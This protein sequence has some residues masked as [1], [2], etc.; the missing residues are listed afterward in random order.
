MAQSSLPSLP[1]EIF[2]MICDELPTPDLAALV[3]TCCHTYHR[4]IHRFAQRYVEVYLDFSDTSLNHLHAISQNHIMRQYVQRLVVMAPE[5]YLGRD[6][7]WHRTAAGHLRN[8]RDISSIRRFRDDLVHRLVNCRSFIISPIPSPEPEPSETEPSRDDHLVPDDVAYILWDIIADA[9]LPI[10]LFWYGKGMN[11]TSE[12]MDIKRLPKHL[13]GNA[14]FRASW[15]QLENLHLEHELTPYNFSFLLDLILHGPALR[16]L[17]LSLGPSDLAM[18]FFAEL[19]RSETLPGMLE[20]LTLAFTTIQADDL[21]RILCA[22]RL[23]L[24]RLDLS[25]VTGLS[26]GWLAVLSSLLGEFPHLETIE[27]DTLYGGEGV[28][29]STATTCGLS[30][31]GF[32]RGRGSLEEMGMKLVDLTSQGGMLDLSKMQGTGLTI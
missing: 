27:L 6:R 32:G 2:E 25:G 24:R 7:P 31:K 1:L 10:K 11:Y 5:P 23:S 26:T 19:A 30:Q 22:S 20:R 14:G 28:T 8:P 16:K 13:I 15:M 17:Y 12:T 3:G 18:E 29:L 4:T 9:S 21:L